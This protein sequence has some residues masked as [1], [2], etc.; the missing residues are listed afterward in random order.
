MHVPSTH[1]PL[2]LQVVLLQKSHA[3]SWNE[4]EPSRIIRNSCAW[5]H[6]IRLRV[7]LAWQGSVP[8]GLSEKQSS[9]CVWPLASTHQTCRLRVPSSHTAEHSLQAPTT[10]AAGR[11]GPSL[12]H[13]FL[14]DCGFVPI[15][16]LQTYKHTHA[17]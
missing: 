10:H 13:G 1:S 17:H 8:V 5:D 16:H 3:R 9:S 12:L 7:E 14:S 11:H 6:L 2:A 15:A 4:I